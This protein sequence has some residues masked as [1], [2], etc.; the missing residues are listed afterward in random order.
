M[1]GMLIAKGAAR[2]WATARST[3]GCKKGSSEHLFL[4]SGAIRRGSKGTRCA[5]SAPI[6][7][8][9][10]YLEEVSHA[11]STSDAGFDTAGKGGTAREVDYA[12]RTHQSLKIEGFGGFTPHQTCTI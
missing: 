9:D 1:A 10:R 6:A 7:Q 8:R 3:G 12:K 5:A 11:R 2:P 4:V